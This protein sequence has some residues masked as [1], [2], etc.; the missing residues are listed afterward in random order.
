MAAIVS[1]S[2]EPEDVIIARN[3]AVL[4]R[5]TVLKSDHFPGCQ[6]KRLLPHVEGAPNYRQVAD[7]PIYGVAI[8]TADGIRHVLDLVGASREGG[9]RVLWHNMREEPVIYINGRPFVLREVERPFTNLEYTG[10]DRARVEQME[11]RLK[12]DALQE[13]ASDELPDGQMVDLWEPI[14][15]NSV[16]TPLE[17]YEHLQ[18]EGYDVDYERVPVTDEKSPKERD[19]DLLVQR[20]GVV[21]KDVAQLFN[22]Q[23]GRGRTTTGMVI[24]GAG[25]ARPDGDSVQQQLQQQQQEAT[26]A[27]TEEG[28][29]RG[30]YAVIR[31]LT[32]A[33]EKKR[34]A[35]LSFFME[36]LERYY[37][38]IC[39]AVYIHTD[40][41]AMEARAR[42]EGSFQPWMRSRPELYSIL[43]R[44]LRRDPMRALGYQSTTSLARS[45]SSAVAAGGRS[46]DMATIL[47]N[48]SGSVLGLQT[49]LKSDHCP[50]CQ[51][52]NLEERVDG[53]PN[54]RRIRGFP[55]YGV[56]NPTVDGIRAVLK[57]VT[58]AAA[59]ATAAAHGAAQAFSPG[60]LPGSGDAAHPNGSGPGSDAGTGGTAPPGNGA[61]APAARVLW[62]NMR[63]EPMVYIN[64]K[65]FVLREMERPFKNMLEYSGIDK[66]RVEQMEARLKEDVLREAATYDGAIMV[67]HET[68]DGEIFDVWERVTA[69]ATSSVQTPVEVYQSLQAEGY[70]VEYERVPI[71]DGKAPKSRDFD[72]LAQNIAA[73]GPS[74]ALV[75]NC[76][77]GRGRTTTGTVIA[78]L[79]LLRCRYGRPLRLP[80]V[81]VSELDQ[82]GKLPRSDS[83]RSGSSDSGSGEDSPKAA[84]DGELFSP[85]VDPPDQPMSDRTDESKSAQAARAPSQGA[86]P[87]GGTE[88]VQMPPPANRPATSPSAASASTGGAQNGLHGAGGAAEVAVAQDDL[89]NLDSHQSE[90]L[91]DMGF[92]PLETDGSLFRAHITQEMAVDI[93]AGDA[94]GAVKY[95]PQTGVPA[96]APAP[97]PTSTAAASGAGAA[98]QV[99]PEQAESR[100]RS[101]SEL[102]LRLG[103][104]LDEEVGAQ[105]AD[106]E[107]AG[108]A[109]K[110]RGGGGGAGGPG[111]G[112]DSFS[113]KDIVIVRR[114]ARLLERGVECQE[115][116][117]RVVDRCAAM[118]NIRQAILR[119]RRAFNHQD[120]NMRVRQSALSRGMEYLERYYMLIVFTAYLDS[121][122]FQPGKAWGPHGEAADVEP[123]RFKAWIRRRPDIRQ[124]KW[125]MRLRP[126]RLF[127]IPAVVKS[128]SGQ[129]LGRCS[130]LKMYIFPDLEHHSDRLP[131]P[132]APK[133]NHVD[134]F[135]VHSVATPT[136]DGAKALMVSLGAGPP[137]PGSPDRTA[138]KAII[139]DLR[140]EAVVYICGQPFV[141]REL[142]QPVST[143]K[144]VGIEGPAVEQ[145]ER[146]MKEDILAEAAQMGGRILLHKES[147]QVNPATGQS[148][149]IGYWQSITPRDVVTPAEVYAN[150]A[151]GGYKVHYRR[152]PLTR[153]RVPRPADVDSIQRRA[154]SRPATCLP[155]SLT[156]VSPSQLARLLA[157]L[158]ARLLLAS[159]G[160][161]NW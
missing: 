30:E 4:G 35:A 158:T 97:G 120:E 9:R 85:S 86:V 106:K 124:M 100:K 62:H 21:D 58:A 69:G 34:E 102:S 127:T 68:E 71:T 33:D 77:M 94:P 13:A 6:N 75:F 11:S 16:M 70:A 59:A 138:K 5:K 103:L 131:V 12:Q 140:E 39:F 125:S 66:Q 45:A 15:P 27:D 51:S 93:S 52:L 113:M 2:R 31:S 17:V 83:S 148:D 156:L 28:L 159:V 157:C 135:P 49:V 107:K 96:A 72:A 134:G 117:D 161:S 139:T 108:R 74:A 25:K 89:A 105:G 150:L 1:I 133:V 116:L 46:N 99:A 119:Y 41:T 146:R 20:L 26:V 73:A 98:A 60:F 142:D 130:I 48:R 37:F 14:G 44:L 24:G 114:I 154:D 57:K 84:A 153:E 19:F 42:G 36:Y 91:V 10:I 23:M 87:A 76:Q 38:L 79:V 90:S 129:V 122:A 50:G 121:G 145:M 65:P 104:A 8:P 111:G 136:V 43:R 88:E 81:G 147:E 160:R 141:L 61:A 55:V 110:R 54:F 95:V 63:E 32:R 118:Q 29:R 109:V 67:N 7:L 18:E 126:A 155:A 22:C 80:P 137:G 64:G 149:I 112:D 123:L 115:V 56:A 92:M 151:R 132:G 40:P 47:A 78:C 152:I 3:G 82:E 144:H 128:R 143:L 101:L 53:A